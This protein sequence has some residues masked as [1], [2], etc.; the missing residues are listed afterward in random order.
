MFSHMTRSVSA[1]TAARVAAP[2]AAIVALAVAMA[3]TEESSTTVSPNTRSSKA[4]AIDEGTYYGPV[5]TLG[6]G[7]ARTYITIRNGAPA[8]LGVKLNEGAL[9]GLPTD[10][11]MTV[12]TT[13]SIAWK[14]CST[15]RCRSKPEPRL[16]TR[17]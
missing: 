10:G 17:P 8:E 16:S 9:A 6:P 13:R 14:T 7:N 4:V 5:V 15:F 1:L 3:C 12:T 2:A 11:G